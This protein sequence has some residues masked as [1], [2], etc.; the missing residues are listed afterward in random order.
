MYIYF[1]YRKNGKKFIDSVTN[2]LIF[3]SIITNEYQEFYKIL[4]FCEDNSQDIDITV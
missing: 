3:Y 4:N 2:V 1:P